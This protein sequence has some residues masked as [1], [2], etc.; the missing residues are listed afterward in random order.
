[1]ARVC[2]KKPASVVLTIFHRIHIV[3][4]N[5]PPLRQ[6]LP[7]IYGGYPLI[8]THHVQRDLS[9]SLHTNAINVPAAGTD[10]ARR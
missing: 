7:E 4:K 9:D 5:W 2:E 8:L 3:F 6:S 1:M 10:M